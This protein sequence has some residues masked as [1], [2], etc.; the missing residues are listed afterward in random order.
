MSVCVC[1]IVISNE[2]MGHAKKKNNTQ[3]VYDN[4]RPTNCHNDYHNEKQNNIGRETMHE[5]IRSSYPPAHRHMDLW[6]IFTDL[7]SGFSKWRRIK[8]NK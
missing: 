4:Q 5:H 7:V 2:F 3:I 8:A 1:F 6:L